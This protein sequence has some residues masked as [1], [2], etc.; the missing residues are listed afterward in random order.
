MRLVAECSVDIRK[1]SIIYDAI[2][3]VKSEGMLA[4]TYTK[5]VTI[6]NRRREVPT[7]S[8]V[9]MKL[10]RDGEDRKSK[11]YGQGSLDSRRYRIFT[12]SINALKRFKDD[13]K[14]VGINL[15]VVS[16]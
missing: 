15:N 1:Y 6:Y 12:G 2:E 13:V 11:T 4:P 3:E 7:I 9:G 16:A 10:L 8:K 5:Q 14:E